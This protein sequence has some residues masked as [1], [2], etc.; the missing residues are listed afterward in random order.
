MDTFLCCICPVY[1]NQVQKKTCVRDHCV[2][3][4]GMF[5]VT[6]HVLFAPGALCL[7]DEITRVVFLGLLE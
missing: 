1:I 2:R 4:A 5:F 7:A 6:C 3:W